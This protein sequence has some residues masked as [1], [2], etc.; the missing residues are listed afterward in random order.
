MTRKIAIIG[1]GPAG[2]TLAQELV[3]TENEYQID[4]FDK[5][6]EIGGAIYTGIP[7]YRMPKTFLEK[8]YNGLIEAGVK[9]HFNTFVDQ[10]MFK[11]LQANYDYVV[12]AIGAQIENT[13]GF[14]TGNGVVAGLTL[15]YDLN[16]NHKQEDFKKYKKAIVWGGGNVAMD[17]ARSLVRIIDDVTIVYRR[18]L[19]EMPASP[20][21]IKACEKEGVKIAFLN[22]IKDILKDENGNVC[23]V[24]VA[25]MELGEMDESGRASCHEVKDSLF[26][27]ECD[28]VAMAIGQ[29]VDFTPLNDDLKTTDTHASTLKNV[30]IIGDAFTGPKTIGSAVMEGKKI[31]KEI[32]AKYRD[33]GLV[34]INVATENGS[35]AREIWLQAIEE[36]G[37]TWTQILNNEGKNKCDVVKDYAIT[38]FPTKVLIDGDGK[39]VVR[40]VGESEPIDAKLKEAFGE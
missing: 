18:S 6:A 23:G 37:M 5:E 34:V 13:F 33:K 2:Y 29:K 35:K 26:T 3:K 24:Q 40:A 38:A 9:F 7:E 17:C 39:I 19:Q 32:E 31:A 14:E 11:E 1:A 27:M 36:D 28:L 16:I 22:N 4:I 10:T 8:A 12:V 25:K 30:Y 21:E 15:L 20:A